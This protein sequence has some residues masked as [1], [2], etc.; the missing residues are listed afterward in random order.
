MLECLIPL[1]INVPAQATQLGFFVENRPFDIHVFLD[2][3]LLVPVTRWKH[4]T[5]HAEK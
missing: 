3:L 5:K 4:I 1:L 2:A